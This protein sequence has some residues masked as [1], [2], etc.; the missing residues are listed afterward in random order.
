MTQTIPLDL[1]GYTDLPKGKMASVVTY[2]EMHKRPGAR[3]DAEPAGLG[4]EPL[5]GKDTAR[6]RAIFRTIGERWMWFA[7][8]REPEA[9]LARWLDRPDV[10]AFAAT[11]SGH[12]CGML[13]LDF[14]TQGE[15][16]IV[17]FGLLD[18]AVGQGIGR[19]LM[20]RALDAAWS[21]EGVRRVWL[22]TCTFDHPAAVAFYR[23]SGFA[24]YKLAVEVCDDPRLDGTL[25]RD[26]APH[27]PLIDG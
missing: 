4:L 17:Y 19:W 14:R 7:R 26:A 5:H 8:L 22:H 1:D 9:S 24:T 6:Y 27:A 16:E 15:A 25:S 23:R 11:R 13:E 10:A 20:N 18:E 21:R 3:R 2:L 12:D